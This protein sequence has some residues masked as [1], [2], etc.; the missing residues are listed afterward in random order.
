MKFCIQCGKQIE[1]GRKCKDCIEIKHR[2]TSREYYRRN[3]QQIKDYMNQKR[4][5]AQGKNYVPR[6]QS[7]LRYCRDQ[8]GVDGIGC[9]NCKLPRCVQVA[10]YRG[11]I[12][13]TKE[14]ESRYL[15][16]KKQSWL[17]IEE[18]EQIDIYR[19]IVPER[20]P[21][22]GRGHNWRRKI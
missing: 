15:D 20:T 12:E 22:T 8:Q 3:S 10:Y 14:F 21:V 4:W 13:N 7:E 9:L 2:E 17:D 18:P 6:K 11:N 19:H 5:R 16:I 1:S